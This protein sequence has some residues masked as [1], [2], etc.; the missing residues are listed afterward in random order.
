MKIDFCTNA[1]GEFIIAHEDGDTIVGLTRLDSANLRISFFS[2]R[3]LEV[4]VGE[5]GAALPPAGSIATVVRV[6]ADGNKDV[7]TVEILNS[8]KENGTA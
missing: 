5:N 8:D 6:D 2:G 4:P 3:N 1:E 7:A